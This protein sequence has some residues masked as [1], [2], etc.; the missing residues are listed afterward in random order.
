MHT[1]FNTLCS[2]A[3]DIILQPKNTPNRI[4]NIHSAMIEVYN[5]VIDNHSAL[6]NFQ[7]SEMNFS[8]DNLEI[9]L[10]EDFLPI[11]NMP[12]FN[13]SD[14][15]TVKDINVCKNE[16]AVLDY[17]VHQVRTQL[18]V[19]FAS[20][21]FYNIPVLLSKKSAKRMEHKSNKDNFLTSE[22]LA[23]LKKTTMFTNLFDRC[24]E[25]AKAST[26]ANNSFDEFYEK[27][28]NS[29][30]FM[31]KWEHWQ[32]KCGDGARFTSQLCDNLDIKNKFFMVN[33]NLDFGSFHCFCFVEV[34]QKT[35]IVDC[36]YRQFFCLADSF[37]EQTSLPSRPGCRMGRFMLMTPERQ[38][39]AEELL[40]KGYVEAT[41]ENVKH[42]FDAF[43]LTSRNGLYYQNLN[44]P[45]I[46]TED[47]TTPYTSDDYL[48]ALKTKSP[49]E[50]GDTIGKL[51]HPLTKR[52]QF[53]Y[54]LNIT[55]LQKE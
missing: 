41:P 40:T 26:S 4:E 19:T 37:L 30:N 14:R 46:T 53:E 11:T 44:K 6:S 50:S 7:L 21:L 9:M 32:G 54:D 29:L 36:T 28:C 13:V 34:N 12:S 15:P 5:Y 22:E 1:D 43:I 17:I 45:M 25:I 48:V 8:I 27:A 52:L 20:E 47:F 33:E 2:R 55:A 31:M 3:R 10:K 49:L 39:F 24:K 42:Y 18:C 23:K 16:N 38:K 35:Y 51:K